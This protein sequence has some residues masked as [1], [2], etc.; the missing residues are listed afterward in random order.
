MVRA[1]QTIMMADK[2]ARDAAAS[3]TA[4]TLRSTDDMT[5][6]A[7]PG[8]PGSPE[9]ERTASH[10]AREFSEATK[11]IKR[12]ADALRAATERLDAA[13]RTDADGDPHY[14]RFRIDLEY[15]GRRSVD[16]DDILQAMERRA[17]DVL[18]DALGIKNVMS[19]AKRKAFDEQLESGVLPPVSEQTIL[20]TLL[21][22]TDQ[23]GQFAR[24]AATEVF[25]ILRPRGPYSGGQYATN[26][27]FRVG[28]RVIL[29]SKVEQKWA[30]NGF[31]VKYHCEQQLTAI[32][33]VFHMLDGKGVM[34]ENKGPLV[35]AINATD[36]TGRGE[37]EYFRFRCCKNRN[38]H[39]EFKRLD[40]VKQLNGLAAGEYVLGEDVD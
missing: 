38:L 9:F 11:E 1:L 24:E 25:D 8:A 26:S 37:T 35:K 36:Q 10:M 21:G 16:V 33:G 7:A 5:A 27:A 15:N 12:L 20:A 22:L 6:T 23:A 14:S 29:P 32:D 34:R 31:D 4:L 40:L 30:G 18:V 2:D 17:W 19:V 39:L 13:F 28:R 3:V